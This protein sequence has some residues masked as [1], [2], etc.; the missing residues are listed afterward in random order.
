MNTKIRAVIFDLDGVLV[1][2]DRFHYQAWKK[3]ADELK[4]PFDEQINN[5]LR[6]VSRMESLE[7]ILEQY[8]G[9]LTEEEIQTYIAKKNTIYK[10]ANRKISIDRNRGA[11]LCCFT[12]IP[13]QA[14]GQNT[15]LQEGIVWQDQREAR[16]KRIPYQTQVRWKQS[17]PPKRTWGRR[18]TL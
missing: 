16:I 10:E 1:F 6:G 8:D 4:I 12:G 5:R 11:V 17:P 18:S 7:I 13:C 14:Q 15:I 9:Q 2:T 3:I